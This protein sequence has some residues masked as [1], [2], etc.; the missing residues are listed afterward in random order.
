VE[1]TATRAR[2]VKRVMGKVYEGGVISSRTAS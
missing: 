2:A 1:E